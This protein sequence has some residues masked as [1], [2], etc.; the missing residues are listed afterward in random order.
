MRMLLISR[1]VCSATSARRRT[2]A[3]PTIHMPSTVQHS[4]VTC[5]GDL[6]LCSEQKAL[7]CVYWQDLSK[8]K[9]AIA[10]LLGEMYGWKL[11]KE[12][13]WRLVVDRTGDWLNRT[14]PNRTTY[15]FQ[16]EPIHHL[17]DN[18]HI[19]HDKYNYVQ[20]T[21]KKWQGTNRGFLDTFW[22]GIAV[23]HFRIVWHWVQDN[24][25][26]QNIPREICFLIAQTYPNMFGTNHRTEPRFGGPL[27]AGFI[28]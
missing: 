21:E 26:N 1:D 8:W 20:S 11:E 2:T 5:G 16:N 12:V 10:P 22:K 9:H 7:P 24:T 19:W 6:D 27:L 4:C 15:C 18:Y 3:H 28:A 17:I 23:I 25:Q 14:E 13:P